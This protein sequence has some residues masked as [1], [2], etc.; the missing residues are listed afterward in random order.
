MVD[1]AEV[2]KI[3][4]KLQEEIDNISYYIQ[5]EVETGTEET[6]YREAKL[7]VFAK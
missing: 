7:F 1:K 4:D 3:S 5:K 6:L 2:K